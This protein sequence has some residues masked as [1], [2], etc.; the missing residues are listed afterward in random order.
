MTTIEVDSTQEL[1]IKLH[2]QI[3]S[4]LEQKAIEVE[5]T[6]K[7]LVASGGGG[8]TYLK[9]FVYR[10]GGKVYA[11][12]GRTTAHTA[13]IAGGPPSSDTGRLLGSISHSISEGP[14]GLVARVG[15]N[16]PQAL[17]TEL[18]TKLAPAHPWLRPALFAATR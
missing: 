9:G 10:K 1:D 3:R 18:G 13:G 12:P 7:R 4:I 17:Y 2:D 8:K 5:S 6:A 15:S 14:D 16:V 11:V